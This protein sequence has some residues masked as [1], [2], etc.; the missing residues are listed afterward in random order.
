MKSIHLVE[1]SS[2]YCLISN[3]LI[4]IMAPVIE[5][6]NQIEEHRSSVLLQTLVQQSSIKKLETDA[7]FSFPIQKE[8]RS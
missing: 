6:T 7:K 3:N 1:V 4:V 8:V 2:K 5:N